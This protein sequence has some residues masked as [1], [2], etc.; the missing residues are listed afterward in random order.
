MRYVWISMF[1][2]SAS[3]AEIRL[4]VYNN[5][6]G[7]VKDTRVFEFKRGMDTIKVRDVAKQIDPTSLAFKSPG[8]NILE[9]NYEYDLVSSA[10][11]FQKYLDKQITVFQKGDE[12]REGK[13]LCS[14][15][16]NITLYTKQ[17]ID[18]IRQEEITRTELPE[19]P[20]GLITKPTLVW[21]VKSNK[22]G[23]RECEIS[24]LTDGIN[25]HADYVGVLK[26]QNSKLKTQNMDFSGWV[27]IDNKSGATY[28]DAKLKVVAGAVHRVEERRPVP[29]AKGEMAIAEVARPRFVERA[30]FEYHIY[31]L[32]GITTVKDNQE[33]Q[34]SFI[35][36][37]SVKTKK[38]YIYE[39]GKNAKVKLEFENSKDDGLGIPLPMGKVR[40]YKED[41]DKSLEFIGEDRIEHTPKDEMVRLYLGDAFD[42]IGERKVV[43]RRKITDRISEQDI[44]IELRNHK[45]ENI[46]VK[47]VQ[48]FYGY[49]EIRK[50]SHKYEKKD[51]NTIEFNIGIKKDDKVK[52]IY[53]VRHW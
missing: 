23:K 7:L 24:Y 42:I 43:E 6:L 1:L 11:L 21:L 12:V 14:D 32:E 5:N 3:Y 20:E 18:I 26:T 36:P 44:E 22:S 34:I 35:N 19:L 40:V 30:F 27:T 29:W 33:K 51:A 31:D 9:Q 15:W 17:G 49:W 37:A 48:K 53:T 50:S 38:V 13:L 39:G 52:V 47:V 8:I 41:I 4:T 28:K 10:K 16:G 25:W 45:K 2:I 46:T